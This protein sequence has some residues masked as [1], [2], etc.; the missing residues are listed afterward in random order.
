MVRGLGI[1]HK[2]LLVPSV[3]EGTYAIR[4]EHADYLTK[5]FNI[6]VGA[7]LPTTFTE[8]MTE[9][10]YDMALV[11]PNPY[12]LLFVDHTIIACEDPGD[13]CTEFTFQIKN[14]GNTPMGA[15]YKVS[16]V[17]GATLYDST[18]ASLNPGATSAVIDDTVC[19]LIPGGLPVGTHT[20]KVEIGP[21]GLAAT[22]S[23]TDTIHV[24][25]W[26]TDITFIATAPGISDLHGV[27]VFIDD[28]SMGTT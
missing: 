16:V 1:D 2:S 17:G 25:E 9:K 19:A 3:T 15:W 7:A 18:I 24:V 20:I 10:A 23:T 14:N 21:S 26:T 4:F 27:E 12:S 5:D 28:T 11:L 22:D 8:A 13:A 6:S